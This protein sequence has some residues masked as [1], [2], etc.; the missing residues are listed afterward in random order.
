MPIGKPL[1]T[2]EKG[3]ILAHSK[4]RMSQREIAEELGRSRY[5]ASRFLADP[6]LHQQREWKPRNKKLTK[7]AVR[8]I[9]MEA[10]KTKKSA[11]DIKKTLHLDI[12]T[13]RMQQ[14]FRGTP[15]LQYKRSIR[16]PYLLGR[17]KTARLQWARSHLE[18]G[19][20]KWKEVICKDE[21]RFNLDCSDG[22]SYYWHDLRQTPEIFSKRQQG[23]LNHS[24]GR[25]ILLWIMRFN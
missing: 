7:V 21:K 14:I 3:E 13:H 23:C 4:H 25:N 17:H 18:W 1:R 8:R 9:V 10:C 11:A 12:S 24:L 2:Y 19:A 16:A 5:A 20:V 22:L 15:H 6:H